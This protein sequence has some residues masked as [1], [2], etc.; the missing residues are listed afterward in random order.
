[1]IGLKRNTIDKFYTKP[2]IAKYCVE[3]VCST[4]SIQ[5]SDIIIEPSAGNGSFIP[6][7]RPLS[8]YSFFY[9]IEPEHDSIIRQDFLRLQFSEMSF[10][11]HPNNIHVIG[12]PPFGRQAS[13][14]FKF[15][16][17]ACEFCTTFSFILPKSFKKESF[18]SKIPLYFHLVKELDLVDDSFQVKLKSHAVPCVFQIWEKRDYKRTNTIVKTSSHFIFVRREETPDISFR[19]VGVNAGAIDTNYSMKSIQSHY[20]IKF[21]NHLSFSENVS[22]FSKLYFE[23][24]NTVGPKS[25]SKSEIIRKVEPYFE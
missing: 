6:F 21:T 3:L 8:E 1:M 4:I 12:N 5:S 20:F 18:Q 7:L 17:K 2:E 19:R 15:I 11:N 24:N 13:M 14:A 23:N 16:K 9:D 22:I 25:I 10:K